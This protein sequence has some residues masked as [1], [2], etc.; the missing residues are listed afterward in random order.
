M[1][2]VMIVGPAQEK[3]QYQYCTRRRTWEMVREEGGRVEGGEGG[4]GGR[5]WRTARRGGGERGGEGGEGG[6]KV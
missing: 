5:G 2:T 3:W 4:E 1:T 6:R